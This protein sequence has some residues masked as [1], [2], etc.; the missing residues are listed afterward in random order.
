MRLFRVARAKRHGKSPTG[1]FGASHRCALLCNLM[2]KVEQKVNSSKLGFRFTAFSQ[3][4]ASRTTPF[5]RRAV[6]SYARREDSRDSAT[7]HATQLRQN[8]AANA[9]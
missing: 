2:A 3:R 9:T 8:R 1:I 5:A 6:T 7:P 4:R